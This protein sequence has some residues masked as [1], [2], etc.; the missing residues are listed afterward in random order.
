MPRYAYVFRSG[1][2]DGSL[3]EIAPDGTRTTLLTGLGLELATAL[4]VGPDGAVYVSS[5]GD[6]PKQG[7]VFRV[8][9]TTK[10][11]EPS[12]AIGVMALGALGVSLLVLGK[13]KQIAVN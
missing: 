4:T 9:P 2:S 10:V 7:Q 1:V 5:K 12:S 13:L 3:I 8:D 11:P 6:R